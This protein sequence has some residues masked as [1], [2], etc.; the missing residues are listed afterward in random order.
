MTA[1]TPPRT[2]G[3]NDYRKQLHVDAPVSAV[4]DA[5]SD[6]TRIATWWTPVTRTERDG[7]AVRIF[8]G[9]GAPLAMQVRVDVEADASTVTWFVQSCGMAQDWA[10]TAPSFVVR[11]AAGGGCDLD[12]RHVGLEPALECFEQCR[13]GWDH[14]VPCIAHHAEVSA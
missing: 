11:P 1:V 14:F 3:S 2:T 6:L 7:D 10:G 5:V 12:F 8:M 4:V 9:D 13:A